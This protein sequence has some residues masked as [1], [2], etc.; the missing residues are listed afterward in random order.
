MDNPLRNRVRRRVFIKAVAAGLLGFV[1]G[2]KALVD[3]DPAF[4]YELCSS[5]KCYSTNSQVVF[6]DEC[7]TLSNGSR[8]LCDLHCWVYECWD[9]R[10][11]RT[12]CY[13]DHRYCTPTNCRYS[14]EC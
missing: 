8:Q 11:A 5:V 14:S 9:A 7:T 6:Y 1:P 4:A 10:I 13:Y 3:A 2:V 12:F